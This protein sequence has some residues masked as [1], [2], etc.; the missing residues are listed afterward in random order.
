MVVGIGGY[1]SLSLA[2][3]EHCEETLSFTRYSS[4]RSFLTNLSSSQ[5]F[6]F[7][8]Y[9]EDSNF[10]LHWDHSYGWTM[11][12]KERSSCSPSGCLLLLGVDNTIRAARKRNEVFFLVLAGYTIRAARKRNEVF[13]L[14]LAG[15]T[16]RAARKINEVFFLALAGYT[17]RAARKINEVVFSSSCLQP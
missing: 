3:S 14:A 15:Y 12:R 16:I 11:N 5:L 6:L 2:G 1:S 8:L 10:C 7:S 13:F 4:S 17:I 9:F